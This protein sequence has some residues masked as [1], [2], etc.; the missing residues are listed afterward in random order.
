MISTAEI[1]SPEELAERVRA[2]RAEGA[3]VVLAN[4]CFDLLHSGHLCYLR[5]ARREGEL[6]VVGINDDET[7]R[8]L[9]GPG[10]PLFPAN[11]RAEMLAALSTVD[12]VTV[13]REPTADRL[14]EMLQ[15]DVH[16]KGTDYADGVPEAETVGRVGGR[17]AIVGGPKDHDTSN[18]IERIRS[19]PR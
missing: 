5:A 12:Y 9:K 4:G 17:V 3:T 10:R 14:I 13:F 15:P 7:V 16:C 8:Q 11:Q 6:L 19:L 1:L 18:L 2:A